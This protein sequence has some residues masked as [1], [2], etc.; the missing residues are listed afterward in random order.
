MLRIAAQRLI[1]MLLVSIIILTGL[2]TAEEQPALPHTTTIRI[3]CVYDQSAVAYLGSS[4]THTPTEL[5]IK[6]INILLN[7]S[8]LD[9]VRVESCGSYVLETYNA[10]PKGKNNNESPSKTIIKDAIRYAATSRE[11]NEQRNRTGADLVI[12]FVDAR[13]AGEP[14]QTYGMAHNA[15]NFS[16]YELNQKNELLSESAYVICFSIDKIQANIAYHVLEHEFGHMLGA[17]H[18]RI[19]TAQP[20]SQASMQ[21]AGFYHY[22]DEEN[23]YATIMGYNEWQFNGISSESTRNFKQNKKYTR[24]KRMPVFSAPKQDFN[25]IPCGSDEGYHNN[26]ATVNAFADVIAAYRGEDRYTNRNTDAAHAYPLPKAHLLSDI[27]KEYGYTTGKG[28]QFAETLQKN[29]VELTPRQEHGEYDYNTYLTW[30][31]GAKT[32]DK[33]AW[34]SYTAPASGICEVAIR[35]KLTVGADGDFSIKI[36]PKSNRGTKISANTLTPLPGSG[37]I[38]RTSFHLNKG[39]EVFIEVCGNTRSKQFFLLLKQ[40]NQDA[41]PPKVS[42]TKKIIFY[43][44]VSTAILFAILFIVSSKKE[45]TTAEAKPQQEEHEQ[46]ADGKLPPGVT[47]LCGNESTT[48]VLR[49]KTHKNDFFEKKLPLEVQQEEQI[50]SIGRHLDNTICITDSTVSRFHATLKITYNGESIQLMLK[51]IGS[52]SG[53]YIAGKI[54]EQNQYEPINSGTPLRFGNF[55]GRIYIQ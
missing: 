19:Q 52:S 48:L 8:E 22:E 13:C 30:I 20:G 50:I 39:E 9:S 14:A 6:N 2:S 16:K 37:V 46:E 3:L 29:A 27:Y 31:I 38:T 11:L 26:A 7:N 15:Y 47:K 12:L 10:N 35:K 41:L 36:H 17:G 23:I 42:P 53:T 33:S 5:S 34:F 32:E 24:V 40:V 21:A 54:L 44:S 25:G 55:E 1:C 18:P 45:Q 51:D 43:T 28:E 4:S 49:G